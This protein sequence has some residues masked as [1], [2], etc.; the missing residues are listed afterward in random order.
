MNG[1]GVVDF[2]LDMGFSFKRAIALEEE[3]LRSISECGGLTD[4]QFEELLSWTGQAIG[5]VQMM[6]RGE[7]FGSRALRNPI[8]RG[9]PVCL[10]ED[11]E[12]GFGTPIRTMV[13]RGH[14]QF[15]EVSLCVAHQ[16]PL[17]PLWE[18]LRPTDRYN[19]S[20]RLAEVLPDIL[21][22]KFEQNRL[23]PS[24]YDLW[25]D[26]RLKTGRD[27]TWLADKS[28]YAATTFCRLL[29]ME[30]L[31]LEPLPDLVVDAETHLAQA[32]GFDIA[33]QGEDAIRDAIDSLAALA[34]GRSDEPR[35]AFGE[36]YVGL[37]QFYRNREAFAPFRQILRDCIV[38]IWPIAAGQDV[39]GITQSERVLH[40]IHSAAKETG[41]GAFLLEQFLIHFGALAVDDAR[42]VARK[43]FDAMAYADLLAEIPTL[44]GPIEMRQA[45]G[46]TLAQLKS[47]ETDGVLVPRIDIPTIKSPWR[48]A[49][50]VALVDELHALAVE[51][52]PSDNRWEGIQQARTRTKLSVGAIIS[53]ARDEHLRLGRRADIV[54]YAGLSVLKSQIDIMNPPIHKLPDHD[55]ITPAAFGRSVGI[56]HHG[57][58]EAL[59]AAKHTPAS[60]M[61]HPKTGDERTYVSLS[62]IDAFH[63]RFL[64][65][66]TM[67]NEF[68]IHRR[69]LLV[70][71][72]L[73][74]VQFF[75][76]K[77]NDF[78]PVFLREDVE[79]A[80]SWHM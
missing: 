17:V 16:H 49:D 1:V 39:L 55:F 45:M 44:V 41:I 35:K 56:R 36:L 53:A 51:I 79:T 80:I 3:A 24:T 74:G 47:L 20:A 11:A 52:D 9:C 21:G 31:R 4:D 34:L 19:V 61:P 78:G 46:A 62:D 77:G 66:A 32:T 73:A 29:G 2:A 28:I 48:T 18:R 76:P 6:F 72:K 50:G 10:R 64:T 43:T 33:C 23:P 65:A 59:A 5:N 26:Q 27:D 25:L 37:S 15:R 63:K 14:W 22:G 13:M 38:A 42:P 57:W 12:K 40:T 30:M 54:G 7:V 60:R 75:A 67:E 69:T 58:F 8:I 70:K 68:G 71:L